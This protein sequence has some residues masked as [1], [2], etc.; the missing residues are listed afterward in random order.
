[1]VLLFFVDCYVPLQIS[2]QII[3]FSLLV[4]PLYVTL[5]IIYCS[6]FGGMD[7]SLPGS[8]FVG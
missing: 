6:V 3:S 2:T 5:T 8:I 4:P 7:D 1:M